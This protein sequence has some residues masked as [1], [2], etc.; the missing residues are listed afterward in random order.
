MKITYIFKLWILF[1]LFFNS[2]RLHVGEDGVGVK[3]M[4][5]LK[6]A[7]KQKSQM[8]HKQMKANNEEL[9]FL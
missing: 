7:E 6:E 1:Y 3:W 8:V 4:G 9:I 2:K 5:T